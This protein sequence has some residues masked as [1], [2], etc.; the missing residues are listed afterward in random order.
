MNRNTFK[1]FARSSQVKEKAKKVWGASPAGSTHAIGM[2]PGTK[3]FF[4]T[5]LQK[6]NNYELPWV[7]EIVRFEAFKGKKVLEVGCGAGYDAYMFCKNGADFTGIDITPE[8]VEITKK[9]LSYFGYTPTILEMDAEEVSFEEKFDFV[10]TFGVLHHVLNIRKALARIRE[11]LQEHGEILV[12][13]YNKNSVFYWLRIFLRDWVLRMG[14][15]RETLGQSLSKIEYTTSSERP[16]VRVYTMRGICGMLRDCGFDVINTKVRKFTKEDVP[17]IPGLRRLYKYIPQSMLDSIGRHWGWYLCVKARKRERHG[18]KHCDTGEARQTQSNLCIL[19]Q[20]SNSVVTRMLEYEFSGI[21]FQILAAEK[22]REQ[23]LR[24]IVRN[25]WHFNKVALVVYD[26]ELERNIFLKALFLYLISTKEACLM[27]LGGGTEKVTF[28][29]LISHY[30]PSLLYE[31]LSLPIL[32]SRANA[33][34]DFV[35]KRS[36]RVECRRWNGGRWGLNCK[37]PE[38]TPR[39]AYFRTDHWFGIEAGG[40]VGHIADELMPKLKQKG[41]RGDFIIPLP[42]PRILRNS[43]I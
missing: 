4:E 28:L 9:H 38:S 21:P 43:E 34:M 37:S 19:S 6:R 13:V 20:E 22:M 32:F 15:L 40:S 16:Y 18:E 26:L 12:I 30:I 41:F 2:T 14:F 8:N 39:V 27:D 35:S 7:E 5:V 42:N 31:L 25:L 3:E 1:Q 17:G 10:Y 24:F 23:P 29:S 36:E 11:V 33:D